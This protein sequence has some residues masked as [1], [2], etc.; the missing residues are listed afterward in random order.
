MYTVQYVVTRRTVAWVII[1]VL[2]VGCGAVEHGTPDARPAAPDAPVT[3]MDASVDAPADALVDAAPMPHTLALM[4]G[5]TTGILGTAGDPF[6][7]TCAAG[8]ALVGFS[9]ATGTFGASVPVVGQVIGHC[10]ALRIGGPVVGGYAV[11]AM[12]GVL[13]TPR[14]ADTAT[15][16][17]SLCPDNQFVVGLAVRAGSA[18]DQLAV[19]CASLTL[20]AQNGGGWAAQ[21]GAVTLSTP[22][23]GSGGAALTALCPG[24]QVAT[25][26]AP[27]VIAA[28][29]PAL[30]VLGAIGVQCSILTAQ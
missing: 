4:A 20:V 10:S 17:T 1:G 19:E 28:T 11:T 25:V 14:G 21:I 6:T 27:K 26:S 8:Q 22:V 18:L 23:G 3:A 16:W 24:S 9:G 2:Q 29:A 15:R 12:P 5:G 30:P 7:D 13:L